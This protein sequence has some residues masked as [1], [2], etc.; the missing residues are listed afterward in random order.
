MRDGP[1]KP[2]VSKR[3]WDSPFHV[4]E[5]K[6][7]SGYPS[8]QDSMQSSF[9][10][11]RQSLELESREDCTF[12]VSN[13]GRD[14]DRTQTSASKP[15]VLHISQKASSSSLTT[16]SPLKSPIIA[17]LPLSPSI[18]KKVNDGQDDTGMTLLGDN[19]RESV[20]QDNAAFVNLLEGESFEDLPVT[21]TDTT[22]DRGLTVNR[23]WSSF[24]GESSSDTLSTEIS[25]PSRRPL[26]SSQDGTDQSVREA[27]GT[28]NQAAELVPSHSLL[29]PDV[30]N[31]AV[32]TCTFLKG[33]NIYQ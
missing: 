9:D 16:R 26:I 32:C 13:N 23:E 31:E 8:S 3:I 25:S 7:D 11:V 1:G 15:A 22:V 21:D 4:G 29:S 14:A 17:R 18:N 27:Q 2:A 10:D 6:G 24:V 20:G 28:T 12:P 33:K 5:R 30:S 19:K